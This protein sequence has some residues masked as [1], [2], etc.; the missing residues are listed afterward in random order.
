MAEGVRSGVVAV[1]VGIGLSAC[2]ALAG[3]F[4][5]WA[6]SKQAVSLERQVEA[7]TQQTLISHYATSAE[8]LG[9]REMSVRIGGIQALGH[10]AASQPELFHLRAMRLLSAFVRHPGPTQ[11]REREFRADVQEALD[12]IIYRSRRG[13]EIEATHRERFSDRKRDAIKPPTPS[14]IDLS[15]SDLRW[16]NLYAGDLTY[17]IQDRAELSYAHGNGA[18]FSNASFTGAV[19]HKAVF[20]G[21]KFSDA[22]TVGADFS[23]STLQTASFNG[24]IMPRRLVGTSLFGADMTG[25]SF[26]P[27]DLTG[28]ELTQTDMSKVKFTTGTRSTWNPESGHRSSTTLYPRITQEQL[29][30][31]IADPANPPIWP[32]GLTDPTTG[33]TLLWKMEER[34]AAWETHRKR[35]EA[36]LSPTPVETKPRGRRTKRYPNRQ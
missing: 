11:L 1:W 25:A 20:I 2:V 17:A 31:A 35:M 28:V 5:G 12:A 8:M 10:L 21:S 22:R 29:D 7:L 6:V 26:G 13:R 14:V 3:W 34:G 32:D 36:L 9:S 33:T 4:Q 24:T 27:V 23:G 15:G 30:A 19:A 16:A 18:N